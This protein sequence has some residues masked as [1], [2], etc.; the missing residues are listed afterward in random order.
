MKRI[1]QIIFLLALGHSLF[2]QEW[3]VEVP[4]N[5]GFMR[6]MVSVDSGE[7][8]LG[9]GGTN[10][11][12]RY[13]GLILKVDKDGQY[14]DRQVHLPGQTLQYHSAVQLDDG[15][16]MVFGLC[17]DSL[18]DPLFQ[19]Y[20]RVDV[21]NGDLEIVSSRTYDVDDET[22]DYFYDSSHNYIMK[23]ILSRSGTVI[24][25]C[26]LTFYD[27]T[28]TY[29]VYRQRM[30][31]YEFD[32]DGDL[33]RIVDDNKKIGHINEI[34]YAPHS[35]NLMLMVL[36][37]FPPNDATGIYVA[38]TSLNIV[39]RQDFFRV[40]GGINPYADHIWEACCEGRWIDGDCVI[41]DAYTIRY[42][43]KDSLRPTFYYDK[44]YKLDSALNVRAELRLPPYDSC[45]F[46]PEGTTTAYVD[47]STIFAFTF[48]RHAIHDHDMQHLNVALV[49]KNLNLLGRKVIRKEDEM[50]SMWAPPATFNDGGCLA[51]VRTWNGSGYQGEPFKRNELMKFRRDDIEIT[52]D[53][54]HET[55]A[56]DVTQAYPN[57]STGIINIPV[58]DM[59]LR[60]ARLQIIDIKG[61]KWLDCIVNKPGNVITVDTQNLETG[62]YVYKVVADNHEIVRGKFIK[63]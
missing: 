18:R 28:G 45:S 6:D 25:A 61:G 26:V 43:G 29:P 14:T 53:V 23:S 30:R 13:D 47:D 5:M 19:Q 22:F 15:N 7:Y 42:D 37:S 60:N 3:V 63:E 1:F 20:L 34:F 17:D 31:F 39:A 21:F 33:L 40:Q 51:F 24:M 62:L 27:D 59:E 49:D 16:F 48:C 32:E 57:P 35:D 11:N 44:L 38:D 9:I 10:V 36:G 52:W 8:V 55:E 12:Y 2:A 58:K 41:Y 50:F 46:S 54:V 4:Y 56:W